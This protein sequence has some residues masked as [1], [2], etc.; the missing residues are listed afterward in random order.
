MSEKPVAKDDIYT[1]DCVVCHNCCEPNSDFCA[2]CIEK[3]KDERNFG[4]CY[5]CHDFHDH[6]NCIG[7]PCQCPCP[8]PDQRKRD[9]EIEMALSRLTPYERSL[10]AG[11]L[12]GG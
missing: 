3:G 12:T 5:V 7:L 6:E 9:A 11:K 1:R 8:Q 2:D 4:R 10:I